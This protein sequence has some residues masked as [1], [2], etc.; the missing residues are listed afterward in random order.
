MIRELSKNT[1]KTHTMLKINTN[2]RKIVSNAQNLL[3]QCLWL[4]NIQQMLKNDE[5][6]ITEYSKTHR[7]LINEHESTKDP[8]KC[9][10]FTQTVAYG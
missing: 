3:K 7:M 4:N 5:R 6:I 8:L 2:A 10:K 9:S 1:Q